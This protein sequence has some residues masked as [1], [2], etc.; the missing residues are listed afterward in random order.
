MNYPT[1]KIKKA[2]NST[3]KFAA[4]AVFPI[5]KSGRNASD[6]HDFLIDTA[7]IIK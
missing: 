7:I 2:P 4:L 3:A 1:N 5:F 6:E